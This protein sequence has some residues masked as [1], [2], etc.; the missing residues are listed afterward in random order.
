LEGIAISRDCFERAI[1]TYPNNAEAHRHLAIC[2]MY[3]WWSAFEPQGLAKAFATASRAVELD[4]ASGGCHQ[5]LAV[6]RLWAEGP[7]AAGISIARS[8]DLN[9]GDPHA[10]IFA[11]VIAA[12]SGNLPD[13]RHYTGHAFRVNPLPPLCFP[14]LSGIAAFVEGRYADALPGF[15]ALP[16]CA[17]DNTYA[18]ACHGLMGDKEKAAQIRE[19]NARAGRKWDYRVG[20]VREPF[21]MSEPRERLLEGLRKAHAI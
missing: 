7:E 12:Y 17:Y 2:N 21:A 20:A 19:R 10:L 16:G 1:A 9:P 4:P 13:A 15:E 5:A 8:L 3:L 11:G 6:C 18:L 14:E